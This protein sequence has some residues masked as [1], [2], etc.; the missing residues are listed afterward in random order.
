MGAHWR[1]AW[2][3]CGGAQ[4][5][6]L[7]QSDQTD[8]L[9]RHDEM[10]AVGRGWRA[11]WMLLRLLPIAAANA[12]TGFASRATSTRLAAVSVITVYN[13]KLAYLEH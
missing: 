2:T 7:N 1:G 9:L 5:F 6:A 10:Q 4:G 3:T 13:C 12:N 8:E 11:S